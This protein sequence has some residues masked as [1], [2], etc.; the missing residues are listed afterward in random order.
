MCD[1]GQQGLWGK[2]G[3]TPRQPSGMPGGLPQLHGLDHLIQSVTSS[4]PRALGY[5]S[6]VRTTTSVC[7]SSQGSGLCV[8]HAHPLHA[9]LQCHWLGAAP[10]SGPKSHL[11]LQCQPCCIGPEDALAPSNDISAVG[12]TRSIHQLQAQHRVAARKG[13]FNADVGHHTWSMASVESAS[14]GK[15]SGNNN[16]EVCT[17]T[18]Q[19]MDTGCVQHCRS[20]LL[21]AASHRHERAQGQQSVPYG[22]HLCV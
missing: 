22:T 15:G 7:V 12:P 5:T 4:P 17:L 21:L 10:D 16:N 3:F 6:L 20:H 2:V 13:A 9:M 1:G 18:V 19:H 8:C 14:T 11:L